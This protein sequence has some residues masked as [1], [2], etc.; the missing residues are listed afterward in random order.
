MAPTR[1]HRSL[2]KR[3]KIDICHRVAIYSNGAEIDNSQQIGDMGVFADKS[4]A[5][6]A[7][8]GMQPFH[9]YQ[10]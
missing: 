10:R 9:W 2:I 7:K 5:N 1:Y 4:N 3:K 8:E 6:V